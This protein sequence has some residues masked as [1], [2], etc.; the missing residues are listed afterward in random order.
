MIWQASQPDDFLSVCVAGRAAQFSKF[1]RTIKEP[2]MAVATKSLNMH[3]PYS[4]DTGT[5]DARV[6]KTSPGNYALGYKNNKGVFMVCYVGR[7]DSDVA[8]RLKSWV[9]RTSRSLFKFS[10][11]TSPKAAFEKECHNWHDFEP[12]DNIAHPDRPNGTTWTCP[13]CNHFG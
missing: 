3:G 13:R 5:I 11:A 7:S 1:L 4:L 8:A 10:Y 2:N 12:P 6:T 9:G